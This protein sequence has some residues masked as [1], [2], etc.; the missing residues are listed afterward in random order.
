MCKTKNEI[1]DETNDGHMGNPIV[2][3]KVLIW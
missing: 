1:Q 2:A 3:H